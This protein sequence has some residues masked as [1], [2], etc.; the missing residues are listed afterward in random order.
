MAGTG[1]ADSRRPLPRETGTGLTVL[2]E[3][4]WLYSRRDPAKS[5]IKAAESVDLKPETLIL[6]P[7]PLLGYGLSELQD[8]LPQRCCVLGVEFD[9]NLMAL[10]IGAI[11]PDIIRHPLFRYVRTSSVS[12]LLEIVDSLP[13]APFRRVTRVDLSAGASVNREFY[14]TA[15]TALDEYVSRWW[16]NRLTLIRM[17]RNYARNL[18]WNLGLARAAIPFKIPAGKAPFLAAAGPSL[19][20]AIPLLR[21][22]ADRLFIV[23]VDTAA[24]YLL[25]SGIRAD[26]IA[27]V[28]SQFWISPAFIGLAGSK[29]PILADMTA[30]PSAVLST[31]GPISF[32][33]SEYAKTSL[34]RRICD[35]GSPPLTIPP[36]GSVGLSALYVLSLLRSAGQ[37]LFFAGL[38][39]SWRGGYTH[40]RCAPAPLSALAKHFRLSP[41]SETGLPAQGAT[42]RYQ[43]RGY[44]VLADPLLADYAAQGSA[45]SGLLSAE[46]RGPVFDVGGEGIDMGFPVIDEAGIERELESAGRSRCACDD[47]S[48]RDGI[49][50]ADTSVFLEAEDAMLAEAGILIA[51]HLAGDK[52]D[53]PRIEA[54][55]S[56]L[57]YLWIHFPDAARGYSLNADFLARVAAGIGYFRKS[58]RRGINSLSS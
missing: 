41:A 16:K 57:D 2:Y 46:N 56:D 23:A 6:C 15:V 21:R 10:S 13:N 22:F 11:K 28:E 30:R 25:D 37:P 42:R 20:R 44:S 14:D 40:V 8:R 12:R 18:I 3:N 29:I 1:S 50:G 32:F 17:G 26:A 33:L 4:R 38:D 19:E 43:T 9:E 49:A 7:S 5:S 31:G 58:V 54:L 27:I 52:K 35:S 45:I 34:L 55:L 48:A 36:L 53:T 51:R 47:A 39:F 24:R